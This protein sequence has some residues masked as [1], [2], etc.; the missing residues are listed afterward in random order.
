MELQCSTDEPLRIPSGTLPSQT[1]QQWIHSPLKRGRLWIDCRS[2]Q[3]VGTSRCSGRNF[4][5]HHDVEGQKRAGENSEDDALLNVDRA[6]VKKTITVL[7]EHPNYSDMLDGKYQTMVLLLRTI[8][9][10]WI[11]LKRFLSIRPFWSLTNW[12]V[13]TILS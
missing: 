2:L 8:F 12:M 5:V 11:T 1:Q 6:A 3:R 13:Y 7:I 10:I 4:R 9:R